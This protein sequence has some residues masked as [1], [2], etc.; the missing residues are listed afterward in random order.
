MVQ[1]YGFDHHR[2][3]LLFLALQLPLALHKLA[4]RDIA[5]FAIKHKVDNILPLRIL[6]VSRTINPD[7]IS[8]RPLRL[9]KTV[10][11]PIP[12]KRVLLSNIA[13]LEAEQ[14]LEVDVA[15]GAVDGGRV[16]GVL[17]DA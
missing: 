8:D 10:Q 6:P 3:W 5:H 9:L 15:V 7:I 12:N 11:L 16:Y 14:F 2:C 4:G 13:A 17:V 1:L